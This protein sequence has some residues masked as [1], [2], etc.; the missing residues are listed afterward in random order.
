LAKRKLDQELATGTRGAAELPLP[1]SLAGTTVSVTDSAGTTRPAPL[2]FV[3]PEQVN[4][5][6]PAGTADRTA[7]VAI[8]NLDGV[9]S[10]GTVRVERVAPGVFTANQSGRGV[11]AALVVRARPAGPLEISNAFRCGQ[12]PGSCVPEPIDLGPESQEV[13]LILFGTGI[14]GA[15]SPGD[16]SV[17]IGGVAAEV[18]FAGP[19]SQFAGLDQVNVRMPRAL[20]G[21]G[22]VELNLS[23]SGRMANAVV[24]DIR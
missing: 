10:V 1:T 11:P 20:A 9:V 12:G 5:L 2:F 4:Y 6:L 18:T 16:V 13:F 21:R 22:A 8:T 24:V 23:V 17:R 15:A 19:Q 7:E 3:S 14:R